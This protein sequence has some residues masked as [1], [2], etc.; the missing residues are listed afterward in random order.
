MNLEE[1]QILARGGKPPRLVGVN[2]KY[3]IQRMADALVALFE[4]DTIIKH[5]WDRPMGSITEMYSE[6]H[7][8]N[9]MEMQSIESSA[10][11]TYT[12]N[13]AT[14][15][16]RMLAIHHAEQVLK[17]CHELGKRDASLDGL[18]RAKEYLAEANRT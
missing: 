18:A 3:I 17:L 4:N 2:D 14:C 12:G 15:N 8:L 6:Q 1:A 5:P 10:R 7:Q 13:F 9:W 11:G 16:A